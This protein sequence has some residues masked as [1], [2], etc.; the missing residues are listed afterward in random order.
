MSKFNKVTSKKARSVGSIIVD[1][2][3]DDEEEE[4]M[5]T[6]RRSKGAAKVSRAMA[7]VTFNEDDDEEE[8]NT[9]RIQQLELGMH[10]LGQQVINKLFILAIILCVFNLF[11]CFIYS[12][13]FYHRDVDRHA[14]STFF[15]QEN[16]F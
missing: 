3:E 8:T 10:A 14:N 13:V 2:E 9:S 16:P 7:A 6:P 5:S 11:S 4:E 15:Q 12:A 1:D